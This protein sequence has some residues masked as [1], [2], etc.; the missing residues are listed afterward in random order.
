MH[1]FSRVGSVNVAQL[2]RHVCCSPLHFIDRMSAPLILFQGLD[3]KIV[4]PNQAEM[5]V[6]ALE[7]KGLPVAYVAFAGEGH[8]F[9][10]AD[11]IRRAYEASLSFMAQLFGFEP[12]DELEP[13]TIEN[14]QTAAH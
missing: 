11:A 12:A 9:R 10:G 6:D 7:R 5:M 8:G 2:L 1:A 14:L 13:V 3:D 4:P